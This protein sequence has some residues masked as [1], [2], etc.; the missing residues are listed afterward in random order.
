[1]EKQIKEASKY[2]SNFKFETQ[3]FSFGKCTSSNS[4]NNN[5]SF[6]ILEH[7]G[8]SLEFEVSS[9]SQ[10]YTKRDDLNTQLHIAQVN[11]ICEIKKLK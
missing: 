6:Q 7:F 4:I 10:P 11:L 8:W 2:F 9:Q 5:M 1:M 3:N